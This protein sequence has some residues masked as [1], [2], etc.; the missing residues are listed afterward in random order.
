MTESQT[1]LFVTQSSNLLTD[2]LLMLISYLERSVAMDSIVFYLILV[3]FQKF[4]SQNFPCIKSVTKNPNRKSGLVYQTTFG[5]LTGEITIK[6]DNIIFR[7]GNQEV[8]APVDR[9]LGEAY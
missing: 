7:I 8:V 4:C 3:R 6:G 2:G 5:D 9:F 1:R